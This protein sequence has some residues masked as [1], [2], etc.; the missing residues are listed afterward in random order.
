MFHSSDAWPYNFWGDMAEY[1]DSLSA[2]SRSIPDDFDES[3]DHVLKML[4]DKRGAE[5]LRMYYK[6][7]KS[8]FEIA[9]A[10]GNTPTS[11]RGQ[12]QK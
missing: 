5:M 9:C 1:D 7:G 3:F 10:F 2:V 4:S 11:V 12:I 6:E 8:F